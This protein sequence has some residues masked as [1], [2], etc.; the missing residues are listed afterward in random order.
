VDYSTV[1]DAMEGSDPGLGA[2]PYPYLL[3]ALAKACSLQVGVSTSTSKDGGTK[4]GSDSPDGGAEAD[5][6]DVSDSGATAAKAEPTAAAPAPHQVY[7]NVRMRIVAGDTSAWFSGPAI[8]A[9]VAAAVVALL[10]SVKAGSGSSNGK[11]GGSWPT[12]QV[13]AR[14][15]VAALASFAA[16]SADE[17]ARTAFWLGV[18]GLCIIDDPTLAAMAEATALQRSGAVLYCSNHD[19]GKTLATK[20]CEGCKE[21]FCDECDHFFHLPRAKRAHA[22][23]RVAKKGATIVAVREGHAVTATS[24]TL[25]LSVTVAKFEG[26]VQLSATNTPD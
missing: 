9:E 20:T 11:G 13:Q 16:A 23:T 15:R 26:H 10:E 19:D 2:G 14:E 18:G 6:G 4:G 25:K 22:R 21:N 3:L 8:S 7:D 12:L 1:A 24:A 5:V 17:L